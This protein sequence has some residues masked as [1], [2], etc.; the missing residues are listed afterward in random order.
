MSMA[1]TEPFVLSVVLVVYLFRNE[2]R[3]VLIFLRYRLSCIPRFKKLAGGWQPVEDE[4]GAKT[5]D[6]ILHQRTVS[7][8]SSIPGIEAVGHSSDSFSNRVQ[9]TDEGSI[10]SHLN[11]TTKLP[12]PFLPRLE[13]AA[14]IDTALT[15]IISVSDNSRDEAE[16]RGFHASSPDA[17]HEQ[18]NVGGERQR[19][20][21]LSYIFAEKRRSRILECSVNSSVSRHVALKMRKKLLLRH[22]HHN[23]DGFVETNDSSGSEPDLQYRVNNNLSFLRTPLLSNIGKDSKQEEAVLDA[24]FDGVKIKQR[25]HRRAATV[26]FT[27]KGVHF[28]PKITV[29]LDKSGKFETAATIGGKKHSR[30]GSGGMCSSR[31]N[32]TP[33]RVS[34]SSAAQHS[35]VRSGLALRRCSS[36]TDPTS[37]SSGAA[38]RSISARDK[39]ILRRVRSFQM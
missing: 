14:P 35:S 6:D 17:P 19:N 16:K 10:V 37:S 13:E 21:D 36:G 25:H 24:S 8:E 29:L 33:F 34:K 3:F 15:P 2:I 9:P 22:R 30:K 5:K 7:L 39:I 20:L 11:D 4:N 31:K 28:D 18:P 38:R 32:Q 27:R 1:N 23:Y 12:H 26:P